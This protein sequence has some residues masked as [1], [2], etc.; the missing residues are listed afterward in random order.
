MTFEKAPETIAIDDKDTLLL[1][2]TLEV[3]LEKDGHSDFF[4]FEKVTFFIGKCRPEMTTK[5]IE[6]C[7]NSLLDQKRKDLTILSN[8]DII[9]IVNEGNLGE[10]STPLN[11][12]VI[13][14]SQLILVSIF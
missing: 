13:F 12:L 8:Y 6:D 14:V 1:K 5:E 9:Q 3:W 7:V 4:N 11:N 10:Q 2:K